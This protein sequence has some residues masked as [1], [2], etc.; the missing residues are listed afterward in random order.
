MIALFVDVLGV[1]GDKEHSDVVHRIALYKGYHC[2]NKLFLLGS[3]RCFRSLFK[4]Y[5][6]SGR[7]LKRSWMVG[8]LKTMSE[9]Y[10]KCKYF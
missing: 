8:L 5:R 2:S 3:T 6:E 7:C 9:N 10:K 4:I 1:R